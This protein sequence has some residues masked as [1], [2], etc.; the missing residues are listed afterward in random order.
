MGPCGHVTVVGRCITRQRW[1]VNGFQTVSRH[2][3]TMRMVMNQK[4][5]T[6]PAVT[7]TSCHG[8]GITGDLGEVSG[9]YVNCRRPSTPADAQAV[10]R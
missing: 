1:V 2:I 7:S 10:P 9:P 5:L 6:E 3:G 8:Q 4:H